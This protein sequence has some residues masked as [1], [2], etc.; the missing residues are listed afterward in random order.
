MFEKVIAERATVSPMKSMTMLLLQKTEA[1]NDGKH[2][3]YNK[4]ENLL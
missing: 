3:V 1:G 2:I 4:V